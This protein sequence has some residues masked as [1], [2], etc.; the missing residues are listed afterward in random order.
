[1]SRPGRPDHAPTVSGDRG[2]DGKTASGHQRD[3]HREGH[4]PSPLPR[5]RLVDQR[6]EVFG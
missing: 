6:L 2:P 5:P 3:H 1:M 4:L